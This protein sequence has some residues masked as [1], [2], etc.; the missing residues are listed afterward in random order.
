MS[1]GHDRERAVK[2]LLQTQD[3]WVARAAG[4]L[5]DADLVALRSDRRPRLIEVKSTAGGPYERF[6]PHDRASLLWAAKMA[7]AEAWLAWWPPRGKLVWL[8]SS[9]WPQP[10][11]ALEVAA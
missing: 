3:W 1:R 6:G 10:R 5:G 4:S 11:T 7:G 2:R 8:H 9:E